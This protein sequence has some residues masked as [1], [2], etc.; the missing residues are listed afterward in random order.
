MLLSSVGIY[1][2]SVMQENLFRLGEDFGEKTSE[3]VWEQ[4]LKQTMNAVKRLTVARTAQINSEMDELEEDAELLSRTMT[5]IMSNPNKY[6]PRDFNELSSREITANVPFILFSE[7]IFYSRSPALDEEI[8]IASN[9]ED[10]LIDLHL[11]YVPNNNSCYIASKNG[12]FICVD[13]IVEDE[14]ISKPYDA[15]QR[16]WYKAAQQADKITFSSIYID[17]SGNKSITC[18]APYY[19]GNDFAGVV[20]IGCDITTWYD[21][22]VKTVINEGRDCF[23]LNE[24]GNVILSSEDNSFFA[25]TVE[26]NDLTKS[27]DEQ[28]A[29]LAKKMTAGMTGVEEIYFNG[30]QVYISFAPM[31]TTGWSMGLLTPDSEVVEVADNTKDYFLEQFNILRN[32]LSAQYFCSLLSRYLS[33]QAIS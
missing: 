27:P 18:A 31:E 9:I 1:I 20:G 29:A 22:L 17:E 8:A 24:E 7:E 15:R 32:E 11:S 2:R 3:Y 16:P 26:D 19:N 23:I 21:L 10:L 28:I 30:E 14:N 6:L 5:Q 12:Y 13:T 4:S 33:L 25:V